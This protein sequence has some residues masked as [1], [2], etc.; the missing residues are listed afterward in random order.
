VYIDV[1]V[2]I[3]DNCKLQNG[4][5]I[6]HGTTLKDGV[7]VGPGAI[8]SNDRYPRAINPDGTLRT[9]ADWQAGH[10]LVKRGASLGAGSIVLPDITI[11]AFAL[12]GAGSVVT[13]D[14]PEQ[15]LVRGNP[16][17]LTGF[18]CR[19]GRPLALVAQETSQGR[20]QCPVC[21]ET[22]LCPLLAQEE[23]R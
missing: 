20:Y 21:R 12:V 9:D 5:S 8:L 10:I 14:V 4:A 18:V 2:Q 23:D 13:K 16:S 1:E 7:F 11:G 22:Y 3:G 6:Y 15:G 17:R 19:C